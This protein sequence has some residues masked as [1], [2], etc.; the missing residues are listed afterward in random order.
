M[1][2]ITQLNEIFE[3]PEKLSRSSKICNASS[4]VGARIN[5]LGDLGEEGGNFL[6]AVVIKIRNQ[7]LETK[8]QKP[9]TQIQEP[10]PRH[11]EPETICCASYHLATW[12][13]LKNTR[14]KMGRRWG[15]D[16]DKMGKD[17][18]EM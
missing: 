9:W 3:F 16:G 15:E 4:R 11:P 14:A 6:L 7:K 12:R 17:C 5:D 18:A 2:P 13:L 10:G 1:P 8:N